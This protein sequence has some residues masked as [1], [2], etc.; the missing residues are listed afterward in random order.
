M[1]WIG[2]GIAVEGEEQ[3]VN[4][5]SLLPRSYPPGTCGPSKLAKSLILL[6]HPRGF[7]PLTFAFGG[8]RS[9]QLSYGCL[10]QATQAA[11]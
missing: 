7:E 1:N 11:P 8:Q 6:A 9:I 2:A 3:R 4:A 5:A 10:H